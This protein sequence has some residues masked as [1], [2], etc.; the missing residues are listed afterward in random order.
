MIL[1]RPFRPGEHQPLPR[2][3]SL[4]E[5]VTELVELGKGFFLR[6]GVRLK[7]AKPDSGVTLTNLLEQPDPSV[8]SL[9]FALSLQLVEPSLFAR[10]LF[11]FALL[12]GFRVR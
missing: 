11:R 10:L 7:V 4:A 9:T 12:D 3:G 5:R 6:V 8:L 2:L 1:A